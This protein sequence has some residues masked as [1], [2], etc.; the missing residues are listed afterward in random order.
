MENKKAQRSLLWKLD[1]HIIPVLYLILIALLID[2]A[3]IGNALIEGLPQELH[4]K[5]FDINIALMTHA[6]PYIV[7]QV[8]SSLFMRQMQ[9]RYY[10][11]GIAFGWGVATLGR[12]L[13]GPLLV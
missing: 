10:I 5:G 12:V 3:N 8:P 2:R 7:F 6:I 11:N 9:P 1:L 13:Q 4:M